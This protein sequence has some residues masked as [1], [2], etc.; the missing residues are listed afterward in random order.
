MRREKVV[1]GLGLQVSLIAIVI[2]VVILAVVHSALFD[3]EDIDSDLSDRGY[4]YRDWSDRR[5][6]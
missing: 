6:G 4:I 2:A 3:D 5:R 1:M